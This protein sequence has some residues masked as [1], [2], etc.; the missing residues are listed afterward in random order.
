MRSFFPA[1]GA[2]LLLFWLREQAFSLENLK[3]V[4]AQGE[5]YLSEE[6]TPSEAKAVALNNARRQALEQAV[7]VVVHGTT[8]VYNYQLIND[9]VFTATKGLIVKETILEHKC[10]TR[11]E[12]ISCIARIEATVKPLSLEKKGSLAIIKSVVQ[13]PG[14]EG[15]ALSPVFQKNDEIQVKVIVS[16]PSYLTLFSVDQHG[17]IS[18][19]YPNDYCNQTELDP[20]QEFIFPNDTHRSSGLKLR[21]QMPKGKKKA[22]ESVL[23]IAT[24]GKTALLSGRR[25]D[26][27]SLSDLMAELSEFDQSLWANAT[28]GYEARE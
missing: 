27:P 6:T 22:I 26:N 23:V 17:N 9:M 11:A 25:I 7:G 21:V 19:I 1:I 14:K 28:V 16:E 2:L 10:Q 3:T 20:E 13:R 18:K 5:A 4:Q 24:K 8:A 12:Q 15:S